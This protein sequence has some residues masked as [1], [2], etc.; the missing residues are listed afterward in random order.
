M[1]FDS[2][3]IDDAFE[4]TCSDYG[5]MLNEYYPSFKSSGFTERN[6]TFNF[7]HNLLKINHKLIVYQEVPIEEGQHFDSLVIDDEEKLLII[8]E[9]KRLNSIKKME[10]IEDDCKKM[11]IKYDQINGYER[12]K[13]YRKWAI[14]LVDL[15]IPRN[16]KKSHTKNQLKNIFVNLAPNS[17]TEKNIN[18]SKEITIKVGKISDLEEYHLL[19]KA[20]SLEKKAS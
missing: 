8:I 14:I 15:W 19:Y 6:L 20:F 10:E 17:D 4:G 1:I 9:A 11:M 7:C 5:R 18:K 16:E 2:K 12:R 13:D 3:L